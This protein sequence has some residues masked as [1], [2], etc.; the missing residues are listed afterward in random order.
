MKNF[1]SGI[2][3]IKHGMNSWKESALA[4]NNNNND[5]T[6]NNA[7]RKRKNSFDQEVEQIL[8][9]SKKEEDILFYHYKK[10]NL[11]KLQFSDKNNVAQFAFL[12]YDMDIE[13][14][15]IYLDEK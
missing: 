5:T 9:D 6:N 7:P 11:I 8:L 14:D 12:E 4:R 15:K 10:D 1:L 13:D 3:I 2:G